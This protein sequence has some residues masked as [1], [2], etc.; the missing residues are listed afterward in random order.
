MSRYTVLTASDLDAATR[1]EETF[2][3]DV[4]M[5]LSGVTKSIPSRYFYDAKGSELFERITEL[6]EYYPTNCEFEILRAHHE[7][8]G[9]AVAGDSFNLVELG[10]G[11]ARKTRVLLEAFLAKGLDF[12]YYP[13]DISESAVDDL[14]KALAS[15]YPQLEAKGVVA[16]YFDALTWLN[17]GPKTRNL[18]LFL[19]SNI[20]NFDG[21]RARRFLRT[22]W[23]AMSAGDL[24]L[25]GF[26]LKKDP[27]VLLD[28]YN[29]SQGVTREFNLNL[30]DRMNRELGADF[31]REQFHHFGTYDVRSGAMASYLLS[32]KRQQVTIGALGRTF[33]FRAFEPIHVE[34]SY[35][36]LEEEVDELASQTGFATETVFH[37]SKKWFLDALWRVEKDA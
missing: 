21:P 26:D 36:F 35:K 10:A 19:G 16:E 33:D 15:E 13:I 14:T 3:L 29:D 1:S 22:L 9:A 25:T 12:T 31:D 37:D 2:A 34:S 20:G 28:A 11:D 18:V 4:L 8:I 27:D 17:H 24:L 7:A 23:N 6:P 30:L 32:L 5:G